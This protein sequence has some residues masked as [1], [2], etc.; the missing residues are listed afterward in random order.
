M[1]LRLGTL[2]P[3]GKGGLGGALLAAAVL[4]ALSLA[5]HLPF[6]VAGLFD[7]AH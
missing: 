1:G 3:A 2:H 6:V 4:C 7:Y 5:L